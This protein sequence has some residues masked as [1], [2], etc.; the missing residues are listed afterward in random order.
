M[1]CST[2]PLL[3]WETRL[4]DAA[5]SRACALRRSRCVRRRSALFAQTPKDDKKK[6]EAQKKEIQNIV[7]IVDDARGRPAGAERSVADVAARGRPEGA[8]QQGIRA[9]H[10]RDR[11][12]EGQ[13]RNRRV[14]LAR[15]VEERR[16]RAAA[17]EPTRKKD[18]EE[19]RQ[20]QEV[21]LRLRGHQ[22]RAGRPRARRRCGSRAR[23]PCRPATT[24]C[25][26]IAKEPT[27]E[28]APKNA[29]PAED[30]RRSSRRVDV[31]G[32][33]ERRAA[34]PAR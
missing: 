33:L 27:P 13:R 2:E 4:Y 5:A 32:F 25:S 34:R 17:A 19:R 12:V 7:K 18:D 31:P 3:S 28:K 22:L 20:G 14:L 9:V 10:G 26:S 11:S 16:R 30:V 1:G 15:G 6:S 23:S 29:P 8:G 21:R 24:T